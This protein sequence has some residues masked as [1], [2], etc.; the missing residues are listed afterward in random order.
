[1]DF[2]NALSPKLFI[3]ITNASQSV[4]IDDYKQ[5]YYFN[6]TEF[7]ELNDEFNQLIEASLGKDS[8]KI[9]TKRYITITVQAKDFDEAESKLINLQLDFEKKF[10]ALSSSLKKLDTKERL[11]VIY[12]FLSEDPHQHLF[13]QECSTV[14]QLEER[15]KQN[16]CN[17][18]DALSPKDGASFNKLRYFV[19][20]NRYFKVLYV[21]QL[22]T[23]LTPKFYH[24]L[25]MVETDKLI[26]MNIQSVSNAKAIKLL[27]KTLGGIKTNRLEKIKR[28]SRNGYRYEDVRDE[29][30]EER[31]KDTLLLQRDLKKNKQKMFVSDIIICLKSKSLEELEA[32]YEIIS[33][34]AAEN[35][36]E[37]GNLNY[38]QI[39]GIQHALPLGH[40][41]IPLKR[42]L[43]SEATAVNVPFNTCDLLDKSSIWFGKNLVTKNGVFIDQK[44]MISG[45]TAVLASTGGGKSFLVKSMCEQ[46][47]LRYPDDEIIICDFQ[48]EYTA[49]AEYLK[50][51]V[52]DI[53]LDSETHLDPMD[54]SLDFNDKDPVKTKAEYMLAFYESIVGNGLVSDTKKSIIDRCVQNCF[55]SFEMSKFKDKSLKPTLI[56]LV[57]ELKKQSE[58]EA[59]EIALILERYTTGSLDLF[60]KPTNVDIKKK[61]VS[62]SLKDTPKSIINTAYLVLM[63]HIK[64]RVASNNKKGI[65]TWIVFDEGH[66]LLRNNYSSHYTNELY[67][68]LRKLGGLPIFITQNIKSVVENP[69]GRDMLSNSDLIIVLRQKKKDLEVIKDLYSISE[70]EADFI[71]NG[72]SGQGLIIA[73]KDKVLFKNEI[74]KD[75]F[76]YQLNQ[77]SKD[78][79]NTDM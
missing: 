44:K 3:S 75:Y 57:E 37:V 62:F 31:Y 18:Y 46:V 8:M 23:S 55:I 51:Q 16:K 78:H 59:K 11:E 69:D 38:M 19:M 20:N 72:D 14:K 30:L 13:N 29:E 64:N 58:K 66:Y 63:E 73:N 15:L 12:D 17:I 52:I 60:S 28:A 4:L 76:I 26:T 41:S 2:L 45:N 1:M 32:K 5:D 74:P 35:L 36:V 33:N 70:E 68:T 24:D 54:I 61:L 42:T 39:E 56:D 71:F 43:T 10:N 9:E 7:K 25:S 22:P 34:I 27:K 6:N 40:Y 77:T 49:M 21:R 53:S 47:K 67:K 79:Q 65:W 50:G 48:E